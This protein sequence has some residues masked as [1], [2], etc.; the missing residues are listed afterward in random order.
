[1]C[2]G[3]MGMCTLFSQH[4]NLFQDYRFHWQFKVLI[5]PMSLGGTFNCQLGD[6]GGNFG[7]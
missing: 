5:A 3:L 4:L 1:M 2:K 6:M 7:A